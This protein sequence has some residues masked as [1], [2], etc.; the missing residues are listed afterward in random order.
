MVKQGVSVSFV[1]VIGH[2]QPHAWLSALVFSGFLPFFRMMLCI[3]VML[4]SCSC[5]FL[6]FFF[7][8]NMLSAFSPSSL[9]HYTVLWGE[10]LSTDL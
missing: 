5:G 9:I 1:F 3:G 2:L 8:F 7:F 10:V 6:P 4:V